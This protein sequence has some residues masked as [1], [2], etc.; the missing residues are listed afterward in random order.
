VHLFH[1]FS[2][3]EN[4]RSGRQPPRLE[5]EPPLS[6]LLC[7]T[8]IQSHLVSSSADEHLPEIPF[9]LFSCFLISAEPITVLNS[10]DF[11]CPWG[12]FPPAMTPCLAATTPEPTATCVVATARALA[13]ACAHLSRSGTHRRRPGSCGGQTREEVA[14]AKLACGRGAA[15]GAGGATFWLRHL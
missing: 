6:P 3:L 4:Y 2:P 7:T 10:A 1:P 9:S 15:A 11:G 13:A 14:G 8:S 12:L 5:S